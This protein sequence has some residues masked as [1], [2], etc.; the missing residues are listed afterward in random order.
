MDLKLFSFLI[1]WWF[2]FFIVGLVVFIILLLSVCGSGDIDVKGSRSK[3]GIIVKDGVLIIGVVVLILNVFFYNFNVFGGGD[4]VFGNVMFWEILFCIFFKDGMKLVLNFVKEVK[5]ISGGK[6]VMYKLCDDV[7]WN[8]GKLFILKDVVF[9]Y[10][11]IF[12]LFG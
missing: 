4:F 3:K 7:I 11:F 10:G 8:D 5:Y 2:L 12:G 9:I 6:V 1:L